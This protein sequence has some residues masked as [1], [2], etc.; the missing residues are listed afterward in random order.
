MTWSMR[1]DE[2][3]E[4][5]AFLLEY[6]NANCSN[7]IPCMFFQTSMPSVVVHHT[8]SCAVCC[9]LCAFPRY[10][11]RVSVISSLTLVHFFSRLLCSI[12]ISCPTSNLPTVTPILF[13]FISSI[14][15]LPAQPTTCSAWFFSFIIDMADQLQSSVSMYLC[16]DHQSIHRLAI[17][18]GSL[19]SLF[20]SYSFV[21]RVSH[22]C[23][24][25]PLIIPIVYLS[26]SPS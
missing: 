7:S 16:I 23:T 19:D 13:P 21:Y 15:F 6:C 8:E 26:I 14:S 1:Y 20:Y 18:R 12:P 10:P 11:C 24:L 2:W 4:R 17:V 25:C 5:T 22:L 3:R 9:V